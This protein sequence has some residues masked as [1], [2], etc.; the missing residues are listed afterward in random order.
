MKSHKGLENIADNSGGQG[1]VPGVA[2]PAGLTEIQQKRM[3]LQIPAQS[4]FL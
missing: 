2:P 4:R 1:T 3:C